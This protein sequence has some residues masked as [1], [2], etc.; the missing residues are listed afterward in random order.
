[1]G[2]FRVDTFSPWLG[3][4]AQDDPLCLR[5][6]DAFPHN[7]L[8]LTPLAYGATSGSGSETVGLASWRPSD[9]PAVSQSQPRPWWL[10]GDEPDRNTPW[11]RF[12]PP[13]GPPGFHVAPDGTPGSGPADNRPA[14]SL[15]QLVSNVAQFHPSSAD[16][17]RNT[18]GL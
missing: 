7:G 5:A 12:R 14:L 9:T 3:F 16:R 15:D 8:G 6:F 1:M 4:E 17:L 10:F 18:P 11:L 13:D 2:N